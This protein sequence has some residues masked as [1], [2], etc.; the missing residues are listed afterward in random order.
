MSS[1]S[2]TADSFA[3]QVMHQSAVTSTNT[4]VPAARRSA[5]ACSDQ[6]ILPPPSCATPLPFSSSERQEPRLTAAAT[7]AT[8]ASLLHLPY[9]HSHSPRARA[10]A[11]ASAAVMVLTPVWRPATHSSQIAVPYRG[12]ASSCLRVSIQAPGLGSRRRAAPL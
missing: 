9:R 12:K 4:G 7:Q 6:G 8:V 11:P 1:V 2:S 3:R 5:T 10:R